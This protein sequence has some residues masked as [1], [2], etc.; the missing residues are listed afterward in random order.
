MR[1]ST[2]NL[3]QF[4]FG[5]LGFELPRAAAQWYAWEAKFVRVVDGDTLIVQFQGGLHKNKTLTIRLLDVDTPEFQTGKAADE[6]G[7]KQATQ[8]LHE[9][10]TPILHVRTNNNFD[11]YGRLLAYVYNEQGTQLNQAVQRFST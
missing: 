9:A 7:A 3:I 11:R 2:L 10:T 5:L 8:A 6:H 4:L 1:T